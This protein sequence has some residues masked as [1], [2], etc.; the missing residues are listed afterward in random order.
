MRRRRRVARQLD[1]ARHHG[2]RRVFEPVAATIA[3]TRDRG[4]YGESYNQTF[5]V[6][7]RIPFGAGPRHDARVTTARAEAVE[8]QAQMALERARLAG[9][10]EAARA[11][12]DAARAAQARAALEA[13]PTV[14]GL[15]QTLDAR[16]VDGSARSD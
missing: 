1:R 13:D 12:A 2:V 3:A 4:A 8:L 7:V 10:R 15:M 5:T 11:R 6:G 14:R 9:E 16:L